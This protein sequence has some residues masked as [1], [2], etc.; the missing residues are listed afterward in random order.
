M[1]Y[2]N[3]ANLQNVTPINL[4]FVN[5]SDPVTAINQLKDTAASEVGNVWFTAGI[6][7]I[8]IMLIWWFYRDDMRF[9]YDMTRA[10]MISSSWSFFISTA[11]IL[12][13]WVNTIVP[14]VW[15]GTIFT[16]S[17]VAIMK[18]KEKNL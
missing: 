13:G 5:M 1:V 14:L 2:T 9:S 15:F 17:I 6:L 4:S 8:F 18:L 16:I 7:L 10:I 3:L 12:S 11:F